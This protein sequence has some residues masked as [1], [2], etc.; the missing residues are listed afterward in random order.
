[1]QPVFIFSLPRSGSTL[2]QRVLGAHP[3]IATV[4][5][6]WLLLPFFYALRDRGIY[7]EYNQDAAA[8]ALED[9]F[10][11][12]PHGKQ[13]YYAEIEGF[14][15]RL[16]HK[17]VGRDVTY[18]LDKT[19]RYH[20][21]AEDII[22]AFADAKFIVLWRNPLAIIASMI[23]TWGHGK[24]NLYEYKID[25]FEGLAGLANA[26]SRYRD[27]LFTARYEDLVQGDSSEW[28]RLFGYLGLSFDVSLLSKFSKTRLEG[29]LGDP[30]AA[31]KYASLSTASVEKWK[32]ILTNPVRNAWCRHY[33][34]WIGRDRLK[35]MGYDL[36]ELLNE[37]DAVPA[38]LRR[39]G[40]DLARLAYGVAYCGLE[41]R[42]FKHKVLNLPAWHRVHINT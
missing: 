21:I 16:H 32:T 37:L 38:T 14:A 41:P 25:L 18:F 31:L 36:D 23:E 34:R 5:E 7:A 20:L 39:I 1:M 24:W 40:A 35:L 27:R 28:E 42:I 33:L 15:M 6:P 30:T 29:R 4:S 8:A 9:Y 10:K 22:Q 19:P 17:V 3:E 26:T 12:L 13:D 11:C 2:V